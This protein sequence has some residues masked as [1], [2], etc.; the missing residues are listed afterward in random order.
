MRT[1]RRFLTGTAALGA[2]L[3]AG[4]VAGRL[5]GGSPSASQATKVAAGP[6]PPMQLG[7]NL[8]PPDYWNAEWPFADLIQ[9][10]GTL[11][12]S[13]LP[14]WPRLDKPD[15][16]F[17]LDASGRP[18]PV[19]AGTSLGTILQLGSARLPTGRFD[20]LVSPG[21]KIETFGA[22][23]L[24]GSPDAPGGKFGMRVPSPDPKEGLVLRT[25]AVRDGAKLDQL[26]CRMA[27][28]PAAETFNPVFLAEYRPYRVLRFMDWM[29]TNDPGPRRWATRPTPASF[30]QAGPQGVSLEYMVALA[31]RLEA[32]PW[33]TLPFDADA[34]Y[35][36]RFAEYVRDHLRPD[37]RAYVELSNEVWNAM[38][39]QSKLAQVEG[40]KRY[41]KEA[42]DVATDFYYA[43]RVREVMDEWTRVFGPQRNRIVRILASQAVWKDRVERTVGH[44]GV[45]THVDALATAPYFGTGGERQANLSGKAKVDAIYADGPRLVDESIGWA[46][47]NREIARRYGLRYIAYEGGPGFTTYNPAWQADFRTMEADPRMEG[48][49]RTYLRRWKQEVGDLLVAYT[50][51]MT[52]GGGNLFGHRAYTGQ[53]LSEAPKAR[54]VLDAAW[55]ARLDGVPPIPAA[56]A[57]SAKP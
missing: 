44:G 3:A 50:G 46:K 54:A 33:F 17:P 42:P 4:L 1:E 32:D 57:S 9:G 28:V 16:P 29:R 35:Y 13:S 43:D 30:S 26:S 12:V 25:T 23:T 27:G 7:M 45:A 20:C 19:P 41:P 47:M 37:R 14:G 49:Y 34:D 10:T 39:P 6:V 24:A 18:R 8:A 55:G 40:Q 5:A 51:V 56:V 15:S 38:F 48:L 36:R 52:P 21:W 31:N 53:P 2:V 11:V 22:W